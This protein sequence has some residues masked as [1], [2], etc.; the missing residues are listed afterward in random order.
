MKSQMKKLK[1]IKDKTKRPK[2]NTDA[3]KRFVR[4]ALWEAKDEPESADQNDDHVNG[5]LPV[6]FITDLFGPW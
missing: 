5:K 3:T 4:N 6:L 1:E 2:L